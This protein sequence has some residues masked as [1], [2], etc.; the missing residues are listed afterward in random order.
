[1]EVLVL[2]LKCIVKSP[3]SNAFLIMCECPRINFKNTYLRPQIK[4]RSQACVM[5][6]NMCSYVCLKVLVLV[7]KRTVKS[8]YSNVFLGMSE[9]PSLDFKMHSHVLLLKHVFNCV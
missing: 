9:S 2:F 5:V 6:L 8:L 1:M 4:T 7:S 3:R